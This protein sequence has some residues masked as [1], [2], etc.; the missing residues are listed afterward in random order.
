MTLRPRRRTEIFL[1]GTLA[2]GCLAGLCASSPAQAQSSPLPPPPLRAG[3]S[4]PAYSPS[5]FAPIDADP[6]L[7]RRT[8]DRAGAMPAVDPL[9]DDLSPLPR[10]PPL[11]PLAASQAANYGK[12][13]HS[14][15][16]GKTPRPPLAHPLPP[17]VPYPTS[18]EARRKLRELRESGKLH[19]AFS[20]TAPADTGFSPLPSPAIAMPEPILHRPKPQ[21]EDDP[22]APVGVNAGLLRIRP[23][24]EQD[25][26]F[27]DNPNQAPPHSPQL[28]GSAFL[29]DEIGTSALSDW[30]NHSF[31]G[32]FRLGYDDFFSDHA[33]D[34][35]VGAGK[36]VARIDV[37]RNT[38]IDIDGKFDLTTQN[39]SSPNLNN[40]GQSTTLASRPLIVDGGAGLGVTQSFNRLELTLRGGFDRNYWE[41]AHFSD[42]ST[43]ALSRDSYDAYS[44]TSR[45]AYEL[46][47]GVKPFV[48]AKIDQRE[49][50][51]ITDTSGYMRNS[52][53][54]AL[55]AGSTFELTRL[56]TGDIS[57]GYADRH[58]EDR[59][60]PDLR[61][62]TFE[63][64][65]VWT[66]TPLTKVTLRGSTSMDET[67]V[68]AS[69]GAI[70]RL[71]GLEVS[72]A[73][74]RNL[75]LTALGS[76]SRMDY[77]VA[78]L[79]QT[80]FQEGL[81]AEYNVTRTVVIKGTFTH[82][83]MQSNIAGSDYTSNIV[84]V[85]LRIQQ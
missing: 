27:S 25:V 73:L 2:F 64:S 67:T 58:Y 63:S 31:V 36:L 1:R 54:L 41:D 80:V 35:P 74:L 70:T 42:G 40:N 50:D 76:V 77:P 15:P 61:G 21:V 72:H 39:P 51:A 69:P 9:A 59:R 29:H 56:L 43:Q 28:R 11:P 49:H 62:P 48:E 46:T 47:P 22:F 3:A 4:D 83:R 52:D 60:L 75:T 23:Y 53:G 7:P 34:A 82:Q 20:P 44:L 38:K 68:A 24:A 55:R 14:P 13:K 5:G 16:G 18:A 85:G 71:S 26:G 81:R 19:D 57:A 79:S 37:T 45:A 84:T 17:L 10:L 8:P 65:L 32:D 78:S 6:P 12:V 66:V 33:A 30:N